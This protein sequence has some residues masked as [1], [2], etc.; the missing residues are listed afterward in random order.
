MDEKTWLYIITCQTEGISHTKIFKKFRHIHES[1]KDHHIWYQKFKQECNQ[2][3]EDAT[4]PGTKLQ[5]FPTNFLC[6][7]V[8]SYSNSG[9]ITNNIIFVP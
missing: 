8:S 5:Y 6:R 9:H 2:T 4:K 7:N 1:K 3:L